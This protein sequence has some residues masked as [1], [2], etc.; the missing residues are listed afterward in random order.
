[1]IAVE[2]VERRLAGLPR[3]LRCPRL[4]R[5]HVPL[6][7]WK[8]SPCTDEHTSHPRSLPDREGF[9]RSAPPGPWMCSLHLTEASSSLMG[10]LISLDT[11]CYST[12]RELLTIRKNVA[13]PAVELSS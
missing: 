6:S 10:P 11:G 1:M 3:S 13:G 5:D 12:L 4:Q 2:F 9:R 8:I 7:L